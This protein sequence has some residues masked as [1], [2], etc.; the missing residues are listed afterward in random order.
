MQVHSQKRSQRRAA[1]V[2][3]IA[4]AVAAVTPALGGTSGASVNPGANAV[5]ISMS[6]STAMRNFIYKLYPACA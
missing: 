3:A 5:T 6:G 4:S 2:A 1:A